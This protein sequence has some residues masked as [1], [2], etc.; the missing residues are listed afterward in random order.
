MLP[1]AAVT[2]SR[3]KT[4]MVID[5]LVQVLKTKSRT[6]GPLSPATCHATGLSIRRTELNN[7]FISIL[8]I[9]QESH[10]QLIAKMVEFAGTYNI[11]RSLRRGATSR[12]TT[13][14]LGQPKIERNNR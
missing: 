13:V 3:I 9:I 2:K 6:T 7:K 14:G 11:Y 5:R 4:R 1:L 10:P 12:A 8:E